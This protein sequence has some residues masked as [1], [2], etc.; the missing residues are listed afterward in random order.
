MRLQVNAT[1]RLPAQTELVCVQVITQAGLLEFKTGSAERGRSIFEG[2]L[3]NYPKRLDLWSVYLDQVDMPRYKLAEGCMVACMESILSARCSQ[4][5]S[6]L[7]Q[8]C[9]WAL[10]QEVKLG[11]RRRVEALFE[12]AA[13]MDLPPK[14]MKVPT[15]S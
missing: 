12:R 11:D 10:T 7:E 1:G 5:M 13:A 2:V 14:K 9:L 15:L 8:H 6:S 4:H 3:R